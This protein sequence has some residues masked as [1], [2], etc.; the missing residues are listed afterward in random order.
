MN[1]HMSVMTVGAPAWSKPVGANSLTLLAA[2]RKIQISGPFDPVKVLTF[3]H[4]KTV[5][6]YTH[7]HTQTC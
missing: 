4:K 3:Y 6:T 2:V 7:T 1:A 5:Q